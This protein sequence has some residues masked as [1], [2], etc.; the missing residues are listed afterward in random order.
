MMKFY[1]LTKRLMLVLLLATGLTAYGQSYQVSG[2]VKD[3]RSG[4]GIVGVNV[5]V[6][7]TS[8]GTITDVNGN[9]SVEATGNAVLIFSFIGY[10]T[11]EVNVTSSKTSINVSLEE[12]VTSLE[13]VVVSGLASSVKRSNLANAVGSVSAKDLLGTTQIQTTDAAMYGKVP[14]ANIRQNGGAPGGGMSILLRGFTTLGG[15]SQPLIILDGVYIDNSFQRTGRATVSGAGASTQDDGSNRLADINPAD[16]ENIEILKGPSAAAIYGTR[17]NAGVIIITTKK[18]K[19]GKTVVSFNQDLGVGRPLRLLGVD[20][21]NEDKINFF[22]TTPARR[23]LELQRFNDANGNFIDYEDYFY[24]NTAILSNTR[25]S[26]SGGDDK[27]K[28]YINGGI[29]DE[30]G[31]V[32]NT[33]FKRYSIRSNIEHKLTKDI[34]F[35]FNSNVLRTITDRGFT[36]NQ[37][38]TGASIGYPMSYVPNYFN[39][40]PNELGVYPDNP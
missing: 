22:F 5:S 37:N 32:K 8:Q 26:I 23:T 25:L 34:T 7:G 9:F 40:F 11:K 36:G 12:D 21:W 14:G 35:G 33:G 28:F 24:G 29:T 16:I 6:K 2:V 30:S 1:Q 38:N 19:A 13:E 18:G 27:T 15:S 10:Q 39:L 31:V 17:A 20:N 4:E 3:A